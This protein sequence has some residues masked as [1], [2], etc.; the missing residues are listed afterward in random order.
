[1]DLLGL[2]AIDFDVGKSGIKPALRCF[3]SPAPSMLAET[4]GAN[5]ENPGLA[6]RERNAAATPRGRGFLSVGL[7]ILVLAKGAA[8]C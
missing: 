1:M 7:L 4:S 3:W 2:R 5:G 6:W 8:R